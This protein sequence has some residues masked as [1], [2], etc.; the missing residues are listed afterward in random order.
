LGSFTTF[1]AVAVNAVDALSLGNLGVAAAAL[2]LSLVGG[3]AAAW[4]GLVLGGWH[5]HA[6]RIARTRK[7]LDAIPDAIPDAGI[8][9]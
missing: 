1:S 7:I 5:A 4:L 2:A 6:S 8:D 3:L 9:Q